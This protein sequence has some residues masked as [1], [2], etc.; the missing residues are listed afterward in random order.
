MIPAVLTIALCLFSGEGLL[1]LNE[2]VFLRSEV[3]M[4]EDVLSI[5][6]SSEL[7]F[8]VRSVT[9][10]LSILGWS[11]EKY[12]LEVGKILKGDLELEIVS[13]FTFP[14]GMYSMQFST[15]QEGDGMLVFAFPD[16]SNSSM[17]GFNTAEGSWIAYLHIQPKL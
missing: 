9:R 3:D 6:E 7:V 5:L 17:E 16:S 4:D 12:C 13:M 15:L 2:T 8:S 11:S 10:N 14:R 1:P